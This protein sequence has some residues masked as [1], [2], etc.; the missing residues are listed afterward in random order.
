MDNQDLLECPYDKHHR[1]LKHRMQVHL[2]K[3]RRNHPNVNKAICP[4]NVTHVLNE[5][6][7]KV[8]ITYLTQITVVH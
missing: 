1:I 6:E 8:G 4:F 7:L 5:P 3:C 2:I